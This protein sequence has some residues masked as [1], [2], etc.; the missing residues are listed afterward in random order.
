MSGKL[1]VDEFITHNLP[2][3]KVCLRCHGRLYVCPLVVLFLCPPDLLGRST[4]PSISCTTE[5]G[6]SPLKLACG[7]MRCSIRAIIHF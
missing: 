2:L 7:L 1:K 3:D 6:L 5:R 4:R